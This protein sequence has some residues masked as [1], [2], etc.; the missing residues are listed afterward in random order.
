M[1][2]GRKRDMADTV[3]RPAKA[4]GDGV[5]LADD[6]PAFV[7]RVDMVHEGEVPG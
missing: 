6:L 5:M 1:R 3:A 2:M 4:S 7:G